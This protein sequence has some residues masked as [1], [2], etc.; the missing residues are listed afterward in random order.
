M[1]KKSIMRK[2]NSNKTNYLR[3]LMVLFVFLGISLLF[4]W[5]FIEGRLSFV[6]DTRVFG[7][8]NLH[9]V[10]KFFS[11]GTLLLW[12]PFDFSGYPFAGNIEVG[13]FYPINWIFSLIFGGITFGEL[14]WYFVFHYWIGAFFAY[15]LCL[16]ITKNTLA[17]FIGGIIYAYSGYALGHIS[18]M[19]QDIMYMW[20]PLVFLA[21][22]IALEKREWIYTL[23]AGTS[24]GFTILIGHYN[25][26]IYI[27][28]GLFVLSVYKLVNKKRTKTELK[29]IALHSVVATIFALLISAIL[30]L[31]VAEL[32]F[33]SNR[34]TLT[35]EQQSENWSL[36]IFD[37]A[38][39]VNP[40]HNHV[41]DDSPLDNFNGSVDITQSYFYIGLL[42][43]LFIFVA[44]F[45][46]WRYK[47][48]FVT[49]GAICLFAAFGKYTPINYILFKLFPGF[50]KA[51]MAVQI[52]GM[53]YLSIA[54]I[55]AMGAKFIFEKKYMRIF[56]LIIVLLAVSDIFLHG[57]DKR[58]YSEKVS[59]TTV[60]NVSDEKKQIESIQHN[61]FFRV[62]DEKNIL[63]RNGTIETIWGVSGI[64]IK[65][66]DDL[67]TRI[68]E[69]SWKPINDNLYNFLNVKYITTSNELPPNINEGFLPRVYFVKNYKIV[70]S[71]EAYNLIKEGSVDF[72]N[73]VLLE[74]EPTYLGNTKENTNPPEAKILEKTPSSIKIEAS[75]NEKSILVMSEVDY[76][77]WKLYV[78]GKPEQYITA[79][80]AFR[81]VPLNPGNHTIEF[82]YKPLS[83]YVGAVLSILSFCVLLLVTIKYFYVSNHSGK[84]N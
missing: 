48:F 61:E 65:K 2:S 5:P 12:N 52:M 46:K 22:I 60:Y 18:H 70:N 66:Y 53:F 38:G 50:S 23:L 74:K 83:V 56:G 1:L 17:A 4:F 69:T 13:L 15:L 41:L 68:D 58:F 7:F 34:S 73:E 36:N 45:S 40:N 80:Y 78:D 3:H 59:P 27:L 75:L 14:A 24:F 6:W 81:A 64:R 30:V 31:P 63:H 37:L 33:Q 32:A 39:F 54:V 11:K 9:M 29:K 72:K 49:F 47:W 10:T 82:K 55:A 67:F 79:N 77:G 20:V 42:P 44:L 84:S 26:S 62:A 28:L 21:Y 19:G 57:Y 8:A 16:K 43:L 25:T 51:R 35:Y 71:E 76:N